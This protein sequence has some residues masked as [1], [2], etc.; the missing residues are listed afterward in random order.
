M[1]EE[2]ERIETL[3]KLPPR[4]P[5]G[6][7]GDYGRVLIVGGSVGMV[8]AVALA[9]NGALR[10]GAGL[11]SFAAP[12]T[13][14]PIIAPLCPCATSVALACDAKGQVSA[15]AVRQ[16][17]DAARQADVVAIGPG[18]AVGVGQKNLVLAMLELDRP[19][20]LDADGL[21]NLAGTDG[22][23]GRR[24]CALVLTPHPGEFARLTRRS[25][26]AI[27]ADRQGAAISAVRHWS[28]STDPDSPALVCL[29]KGAR[30]VVTD[31]RGVYVN[32]TGNPGMATGGSG[33]VLTGLIA[34]LIGQ[35]LGPFQAACLA[36]HIHGLAGDL[37]A[38]D[39]GQISVMA[40]DLLDYLPAAFQQRG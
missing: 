37:A 24:R 30:T 6:H 34:A 16:L 19:V 28:R 38:A 9:A 4:Q 32:Q 8:G 5:G 7:K 14:Q 21:N 18:L 3:P 33:D 31:G 39:R 17:S 36:A 29:L 27:Q 23:P 26:K 11:V 2:I 15:K 13:V 1:P 40:S 22:W 20:V 12:E 35:G 25:V 10:G